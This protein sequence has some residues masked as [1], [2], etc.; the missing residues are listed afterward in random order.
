MLLRRRRLR[1]QRQALRCRGLSQWRLG[2]L[3]FGWRASLLPRSARHGRIAV[4][5]HGS[6][7]FVEPTKVVFE[8]LLG[9]AA[10]VGCNA[11]LRTSGLGRSTLICAQHPLGQEIHDGL[12]V[13]CAAWQRVA[14]G[15]VVQY[16]GAVSKKCIH[17]LQR[18]VA[19]HSLVCGAHH[20]QRRHS[21][22]HRRQLWQGCT[23]RGCDDGKTTARVTLRVRGDVH[24]HQ[25]ALRKA[26]HAI[27]AAIR[28]VL[29]N[30]CQCRCDAVSLIPSP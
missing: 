21:G 18:F 14:L 4:E 17:Y 5:P 30:R 12:H 19:R 1:G 13:V 7:P 16:G 26:Q 9:V 20:V 6:H 23:W 15:V 3:L 11:P 24:S 22:F 10:T 29:V 25:C 28:P 2:R 27:E 8:L